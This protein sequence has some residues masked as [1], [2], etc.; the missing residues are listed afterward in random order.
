MSQRAR[1]HLPS[2]LN[3]KHPRCRRII[4]WRM[5]RVD[6]KTSSSA[7]QITCRECLRLRGKLKGDVAFDEIFAEARRSLIARLL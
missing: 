6:W 5:E 1:V 3:P 4:G 2:K 7:Q